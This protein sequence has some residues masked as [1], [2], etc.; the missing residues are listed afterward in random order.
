MLLG[1]LLCRFIII[2]SLTNGYEMDDTDTV[3]DG[4]RVMALI[5]PFMESKVWEVT[6]IAREQLTHSNQ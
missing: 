6:R 3:I 5:N 2:V 1:L 4:T